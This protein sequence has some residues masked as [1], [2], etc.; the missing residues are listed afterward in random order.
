MARKRSGAAGVPNHRGQSMD[1]IQHGSLRLPCRQRRS[2][3]PIKR[4]LLVWE[5]L[6]SS[7]VALCDSRMT[8]PNSSGSPDT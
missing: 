4:A 7:Q 2:N 5:P 1:S 3:L 8:G 6:P